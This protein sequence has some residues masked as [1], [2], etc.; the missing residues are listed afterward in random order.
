[1]KPLDKI[2]SLIVYLPKKDIPFAEKFIATRNFEELKLLVDSAIYKVK[3]NNR[4]AE[5]KEEYLNIDLELLEDLQ[6]NVSTYLA[7]LDIDNLCD[8]E[9]D[10]FNESFSFEDSTDFMEETW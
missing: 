10:N 5:P 3:K 8:G 9:E 4:S 1:M 6:I 2:K 7:F